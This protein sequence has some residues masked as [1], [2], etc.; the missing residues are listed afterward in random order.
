MGLLTLHA[1]APLVPILLVVIPLITCSIPDPISAAV[2]TVIGEGEYRMGDRDTRED[3]IR[4]ATEAAKR[5]VLEQ[6]ATYVES[7]T[8]ANAFDIT[9]DEIR[10]YTAGV[11]RVTDHQVSMRLEGDT[12]VIH[13]DLTAQVDPDEVTQAII[14][15]RQNE[16]ARQQVQLLRTEVG[17]LHHQLEEANAKLTAAISPEQVQLATQQR[18]DMLRRVQSNDVLGQAWTDWA[19]VG[20]PNRYGM[21]WLGLNQAQLLWGRASVLYPANPHLVVLQRVL[22]VQVPVARP[23]PAATDPAP[24]P[25][26]RPILPMQAPMSR[27]AAASAP[28]SRLRPPVRLAPTLRQVPSAVPPIMSYRPFRAPHAAP[29]RSYSGRARGRR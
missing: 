26:I 25:Q 28:F 22:P 7:V 21:P 8:V 19:L 9:K 27:H 11:V 10:T 16:D 13:V 4:L 17:E 18:Q 29:S 3:A 15:L 20:S 1:R 23:V 24:A 14:A 5:N 6:V 2:Q 12:V